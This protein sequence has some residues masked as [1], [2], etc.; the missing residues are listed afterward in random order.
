M[1]KILFSFATLA[2]LSAC[3]SV[4]IPCDNPSCSEDP[5]EK[6]NRGVFAFNQILDKAVL[7]PVSKA[8]RAITP[9]GLRSSIGNFFVN[10]KQPVY[11]MNSLLQ[12]EPGEAWNTTKR[13]GTNT[14][15]GFFGFFDP[16][17]KMEIP[18]APN[19]FGKTLYTWGVKSSGPYL[20]LPVLGSSTPRDTV[21]MVGTFMMNPVNWALRDEPALGWTYWGTELISKR[22]SVLDLSDSLEESSTDFYTTMRSF[23]LQNRQ[24][25]LAETDSDD[26][27]SQTGNTYDFDFP[28]DDE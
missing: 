18:H 1:K 22:E 27:S 14:F 3:S 5:L 17:T 15:L 7:K 24:K 25:E 23:Y 28:T 8:Y 20:V 12:G 26:T 19:D 2:F 9:S 11:A 16:A 10:L 4:S 13:F 6:V 21:G